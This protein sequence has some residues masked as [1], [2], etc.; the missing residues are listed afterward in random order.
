MLAL[1]VLTVMVYS[2]VHHQLSF[3]PFSR[4]EREKERLARLELL[5][6][7][8]EEKRRKEEEERRRRE[9]EERARREAA[10]KA[11]SESGQ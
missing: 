2:L 4:E 1:P 3:L 11:R 6:K 10:E 8:E 7:A 5:R 9:E